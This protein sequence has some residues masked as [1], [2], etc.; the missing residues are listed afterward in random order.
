MNHLLRGLA[1]ITERGWELIEDE[2]RQ[3]LTASLGA[4]KLVDFEGPHGFGHSATNTGRAD[5][6]A[7]APVEG[8]EAVRRR[9]LPLVEARAPFTLSRAQLRDADRGAEDPDLGPVGEAARRMAHIENTA[10]FSGWDAAGIE[11]IG[12]RSPHDA[13]PIPDDVATCPTQVAEAVEALLR[14]GVGGPYGLA[15]GPELYTRVIQTTEHGGYPLFEH[16]RKIL[17]GPLVWTPGVDGAVVVSLRGGDFVFDC[18]QDLAIGYD[19]HDAGVVNL[20]FV[21]TFSFHVVTPEA[22]VRLPRQRLMVP[23]GP[24]AAGRAPASPGT[25]D[26]V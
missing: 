22:A 15:L 7:S 18:G 14:S 20:Y 24:H 5:A 26:A 12:A 17:D 13:I 1:P 8:V 2:A 23:A 11:G 16:L 21:E 6:V 10:V 9:V 25:G 19:S 3:Q 4:R